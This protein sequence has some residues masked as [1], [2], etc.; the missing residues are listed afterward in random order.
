MVLV[1]SRWFSMFLSG[2]VGSDRFS[3]VLSGC[4]MFSVVLYGCYVFSVVL[5]GSQL[6]S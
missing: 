5:I 1:C 4:C 3:V 6:F 2:F